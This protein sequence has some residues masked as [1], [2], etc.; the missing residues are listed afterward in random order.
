[1]RNLS[2]GARAPEVLALQR[3]LNKNGA[4]PL[5]HKDAIF[6]FHTAAAVRAFK[7]SRRLVPADTSVDIS[8]WTALGLSVD[9][10]H[11]IT[12]FPQPTGMTCWSAAATMMAGTVMSVGRGP[13]A[14]SSDGGLDMGIDNIESFIRSRGWRM[15]N[16]SSRPTIGVLLNAVRR[17]PVWLAFEGGEFRHAVVLSAAWGDGTDN[18]TVLQIHDPWPPGRG[19]VYG[20][21]YAQGVVTLRCAPNHPRAMVQY[22]AA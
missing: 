9:I 12:L 7:R 21:S 1:M 10:A 14:Q 13:A 22:A 6:G 15:I 8:V 4:S 3:L 5:L 2:L 20:T 16:D 11:N 17:G 19:T 18:G